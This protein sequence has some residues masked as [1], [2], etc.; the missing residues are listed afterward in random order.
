VRCPSCQ[1]VAH[2]V[3][4]AQWAETSN[5]GIPHVYRCHNCFNILK[6]DKNYVIDVRSG[7]I[8]TITEISKMEKKNIVEYLREIEAQSKPQV[9]QTEDPFAADI[10]AIIEGKKQPSTASKTKKKKRKRKK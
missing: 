1:T 4:W 5:I 7:K 6:L 3:C 8:P 2:E 10:R 9:V